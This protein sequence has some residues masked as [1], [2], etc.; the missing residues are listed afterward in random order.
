MKY[1][2]NIQDEPS[3]TRSQRG[4]QQAS[5]PASASATSGKGK[6]GG[7][8]RERAGSKMNGSAVYKDLRRV[9]VWDLGIS[10][11]RNSLVLQSYVKYGSPKL[12]MKKSD[13]ERALPTLDR[14]EFVGF[15]DL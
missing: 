8:R 11:T 14:L 4:G 5:A 2:L 1:P 15:Y 12:F 9:E 10:N 3:P 7:T 6:R 13:S